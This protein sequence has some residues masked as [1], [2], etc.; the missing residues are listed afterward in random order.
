MLARIESR[1]IQFVDY[2]PYYDLDHYLWCNLNYHL[3]HI[4]D[5]KQIN[6]FLT[7]VKNLCDT[8]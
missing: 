3:E 1:D 4:L 5:S 8:W 2:T 7:E 6:S